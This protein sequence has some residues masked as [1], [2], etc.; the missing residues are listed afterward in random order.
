MLFSPES[1]AVVGATPKKGKVGYAII[2]NLKN[3]RGKVYA[4]NPKYREVLGFPCYSS[5]LE[6]PMVD[7]A[8][9]AVPAKAVNPVLKQCGEKGVKYAVV[10]TAGFREAGREGAKLEEEMVKICRNYDI[11]LV[12]P[13]CLGIINT[14][15]GLNATFASIQPR[16]GNIAFLSQSGAFIIAVMEYFKG[17]NEGFSKI[18]SMGNKAVLDEADI[19]GILKNDPYTDVIILYIEGISDGRKFIDVA[20]KVAKIKPIVAMKSGK[21]DAGAKAASS[22]TGSIAGSYQACLAAFRQSGVIPADSPEDLFDVARLFSK[23]RE[24][25]GGVAIVTNSGGPGVMAADA[26]ESYGL[27]MATFTQKTIER[28]KEMLPA[29]ANIYNPVDVLGDADAERYVK[30]VECVAEDENVGAIIAITVPTARL[31]FEDAAKFRINKPHVLCFMGWEKSD[32]FDPVRAVRA[33]SSLYHYSEFKRKG[34]KTYR[35]F[36]FD[37]SKVKEAMKS[38]NPFDILKAIGI[39]TPRYG[40]AKTA[41]EALE[42]ADKIGY[43]VAMKVLGDIMHKTDVGCVKLNVKRDSVKKA[44]VEIIANAERLGNVRI[45]GVLIQE[46]IEGGKEVIVGMKRDL[47]FGP[48]MMFGLGG[49]YVEVFRD[50]TFRIAPVSEDDAVDM[51][52]EVKAYKLLRGVRGEKPSDIMSIAEVIM[53]LSQLS[54]EFPEI[55]EMEINPLR[56]FEKGCSA[57]DFKINI[58]SSRSKR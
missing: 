30:A 51:I 27:K 23:Y 18:V 39:P 42:V 21:T 54:V 14:H 13:N 3:F 20:E 55:M 25:E 24:V 11:K 40:V 47:N 1:V 31:S 19:M 49:I 10:I 9:I 50:V 56:V 38:A 26:I 17:V 37:R 57:L 35:E 52:R 7:M 48:L 46:M 29:E 43:P 28:L 8:V 15:N 44:F 12:G 22:H 5:I 34:K 58:K 32:F 53:K 45:D 2:R 4:V 33:L 36:S 6:A 16:P 41:D